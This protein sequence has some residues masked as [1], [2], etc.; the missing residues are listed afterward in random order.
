MPISVNYWYPDKNN[1]QLIKNRKKAAAVAAE[2]NSRWYK[3]S[4]APWEPQA[5][6]QLP[7]S[8]SLTEEHP[9]GPAAPWSVT[10]VTIQRFNLLPNNGAGIKTQA[11]GTALQHLEV[12]YLVTW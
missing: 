8:I 6:G 7:E 11:P 1:W 12:L 9:W 3:Y 4:R 5:A 10:H 2:N